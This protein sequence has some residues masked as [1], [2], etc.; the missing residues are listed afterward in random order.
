[1]ALGSKENAAT[2]PVII[3]LYELLL[4]QDLRLRSIKNVLWKVA[5]VGVLTLPVIVVY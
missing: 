4:A 1:M 2:L 5:A 3:V